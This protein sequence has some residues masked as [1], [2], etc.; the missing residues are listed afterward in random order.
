[1]H[2]R[3]TIVHQL[4]IQVEK[5]SGKLE[6]LLVREKMKDDS[7][8]GTLTD[9]QRELHILETERD[10]L[11]YELWRLI[12]ELVKQTTVTLEQTQ[13][14]NTLSFQINK[15]ELCLE[16]AISR[17]PIEEEEEE[18]EEEAP[19]PMGDVKFIRIG[20]GHYSF[21]S[22]KIHVRKRNGKLVIRVGGGY[23]MVQEFLRL[24]TIQELEKLRNENAV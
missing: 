9:R 19:R 2:E 1:M 16:D 3:E 23:M 13:I 24:Y 22:K 4:A 7:L 18:E 20:E 15:L 10:R 14:V 21:G 17:I 11:Q 6:L 12:A 5:I 8:Y